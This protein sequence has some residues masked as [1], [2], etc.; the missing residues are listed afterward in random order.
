MRLPMLP[1][2]TMPL[3]PKLRIHPS[4]LPS[5]PRRMIPQNLP[6]LVQLPRLLHL[7]QLLERQPDIRDQRVAP[8]AGEVLAHHH[9][10]HLQPVR[11]RRHGVRRDDPAALPQLVREGELVEA[12]A[13]R[14]VEA[15]SD[16][17]EA[18]AARLRHEQ[19]AH[20]LHAEGE[21]VGR[22]GEVE[23]DGAVALLAEA[24]ELVVLADDLGG[25]A[26]EVEGEGGL[27][28]TE[29]VDVEDEF[30]RGGE[31]SDVS[32]VVLWCG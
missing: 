29:V 28:G 8:A 20:L 12:V 17:R 6:M 26:G 11:V 25:A 3:I 24:D 31:G 21:V 27:V 32:V 4:P 10:H 22:A 9:A 1:L 2:Q 5:R 23:H 30:C 14:G 7:L 19:E 16:E 18:G 15:E 13:V